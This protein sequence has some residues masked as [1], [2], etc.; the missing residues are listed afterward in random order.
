MDQLAVRDVYQLKLA[1]LPK[2][3]EC[4]KVDT[5]TLS[6]YTI[7]YVDNKTAKCS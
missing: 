4:H 3:I 2:A 7:K 5:D 1:F 6:N